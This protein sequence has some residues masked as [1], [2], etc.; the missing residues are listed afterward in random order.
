MIR[1]C[2]RHSFR[3]RLR[4]SA[5][6]NAVNICQDMA[7]NEEAAIGWER[8][9]R[10]LIVG[11]VVRQSVVAICLIHSF[12]PRLRQSAYRTLSTSARRWHQIKKRQLGKGGKGSD[13]R[14]RAVADGIAFEI[15][16]FRSL[17][18]QSAA[19]ICQRWHQMK[20]RGKGREGF[21]Q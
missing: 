14:S 10:V 20:T 15:S 4:Q 12:R 7:P 2:A 21:S 1:G 19:D 3:P 9:G 16:P 5:I 11:V 6:S 8:E 13:C 18:H 17:I